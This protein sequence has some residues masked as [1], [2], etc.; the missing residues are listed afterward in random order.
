MYGLPKYTRNGG[1]KTWHDMDRTGKIEEL[2]KMG[3]EK[4]S[5]S[6]GALHIPPGYVTTKGSAIDPGTVWTVPFIV[7]HPAHTAFYHLGDDDRGSHWRVDE[8]NLEPSEL[9]ETD[10]RPKQ[11]P[12]GNISWTPKGPGGSSD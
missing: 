3:G 4:E 12:G 8:L 6:Q 1:S 2:A 11:F 10:N 9:R 7:H 5:D